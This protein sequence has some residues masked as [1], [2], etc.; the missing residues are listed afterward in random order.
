MALHFGTLTHLVTSED[1]DVDML[2]QFVQTFPDSP[3]SRVIT[4]FFQCRGIEITDEDDDEAAPEALVPIDYE[5]AFQ[6]ALV[7][8]PAPS[9][10]D[11]TLSDV[12]GLL[13]RLQWCSGFHS[14]PSDYD[15]AVRQGQRLSKHDQNS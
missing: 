13:E 7:R 15:G 3:L 2:R 9:A 5:D 6:A 10:P 12:L 11:L 4:G 14:C 1:Y 8:F